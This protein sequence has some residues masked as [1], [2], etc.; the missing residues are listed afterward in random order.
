MIKIN[1]I[2]KK[3]SKYNNFYGRDYK[4]IN[5]DKYLCIETKE[6]FNEIFLIE[7]YKIQKSFEI[8]SDNNI[9]IMRLGKW[10]NEYTFVESEE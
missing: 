3:I 9:T 1:Q 7:I 8:Y 4:F 2:E 10:R 6:S 5:R